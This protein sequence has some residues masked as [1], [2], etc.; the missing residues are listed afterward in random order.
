MA[1]FDPSLYTPCITAVS[2]GNIPTGTC[3]D[4]SFVVDGLVLAGS[5]PSDQ[6]GRVPG[7]NSA[8]VTAVPATS[9]RGFYKPENLLAPRFGFA[10]S[11]FRDDK[12][13]LRSGF[14]IFYDKPEGNVIFGQPGVVPFL[15]AATFQ[16]GTLANPSGGAGAT[17][18]I[19][20]LSAAD[21]H[22]VVAP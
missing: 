2:S 5:V 19:F 8:F 14:G 15:Q 21:P 12:T 1:N 7:G 16:N 11:P 10:F 20:G 4:Q 22:F 6:L 17:P 13:V 3:L 18:T 9:E